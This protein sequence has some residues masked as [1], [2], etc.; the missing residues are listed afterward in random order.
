MSS[1]RP[2]VGRLKH[3][4]T[5][6][7]TRPRLR[8]A[9]E[10]GDADRTQ[11]AP[12]DAS[13]R[14][15]RLHVPAKFSL[16]SA[17]LVAIAVALA[18]AAALRATGTPTPVEFEPIAW[19][20]LLSLPMWPAILSHYHLYESRFVTRSI[21][22]FHRLVRTTTAGVI[23]LAVIAFL[24]NLEASR[25]WLALVFVTVLVSL[26]AE[27]AIAR[28]VFS[29]ARGRGH[30]LR[31]VVIVGC[32]PEGIAISRMFTDD[33]TLGYQVVGFVDDTCR[34]DSEVP[35][36]GTF[37][38][39]MDVVEKSGASGVVIAAT[40]MDLAVSNRL[41]RKLTDAGVHVELSSTLRDIASHRLTVRP[42]GRFPVVYIEPVSRHG[43][44]S[45]A[46]RATDLGIAGLG[47]LA[48]S[49][50][51]CVIALA[52]KLDSRGPI[53]FRQIRVGRN[54]DPFLIYK[55]RTMVRDSEELLEQLR[56]LN[57][58]DGPLFKM[59][60][61][62]R[63]TRVG[64]FLRQTSLDE[65]PQLWNVLR[66]EMSI[67][68]PRPALPSEIADWSTELHERLRVKPGLTGMWQVHGRSSA[69]FEDYERLDLYYVDNWSFATDMAILIR[70]I[71]TILRGHGA[72]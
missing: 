6:T 29:R 70:T 47:L 52:I 59:A 13:P 40:A 71:P 28:T 65:L 38:D 9:S 7:T 60:A 32:N 43:W 57:E 39:T 11:H 41:I 25:G 68:G 69:S 12:G 8:V 2:L 61:D 3:P 53:F 24:A 5:A 42:L 1:T 36:L 34:V 62:P 14:R 22:E 51:L 20:S 48:L 58:A 10:Q 16:M 56:H 37:A 26:T 27:R 23:G 64:R 17:D 72:F 18:L 30:L 33:P 31:R 50:V 67:V 4:L 66:N 63:I 44:R 19:L 46:K 49:P 54:G 35:I 15:R 21:E 45:A 55:F